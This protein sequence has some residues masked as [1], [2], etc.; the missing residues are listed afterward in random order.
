[1]LSNFVINAGH[2]NGIFVSVDSSCSYDGNFKVVCIYEVTGLEGRFYRK[3]E[4]TCVLQTVVTAHFVKKM[5]PLL[6]NRRSTQPE[7][8]FPR[9][10]PAHGQ[11]F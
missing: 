1:M 11:P 10:E 5:A 9:E 4:L 7:E 3:N 2:M 8:Y 6:T